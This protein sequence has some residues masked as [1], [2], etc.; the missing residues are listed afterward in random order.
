MSSCV[1][2]ENKYSLRIPPEVS[3][4]WKANMERLR[5]S[6]GIVNRERSCTAGM[7]TDRLR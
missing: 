5:V 6:M 1:K 7:I 4:L 2:Y 3:T